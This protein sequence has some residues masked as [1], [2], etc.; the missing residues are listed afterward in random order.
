MKFKKWGGKTDEWGK[1]LSSIATER[2]YAVALLDTFYK[3]KLKPT[4]KEQFPNSVFPALELSDILSKDE[5]FD[6]SKFYYTGFSYGA[7][8]VMKL[9]DKR[10]SKKNIFKA[11]VAAEPSCN[12]VSNPYQINTATLMIKGEE[13]H[14][15]PVACRLSLIHI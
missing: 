10:V 4:D 2:G 14:Y 5:R 8:Q 13:S 6:K 3:R 1:R 11:A 12:V 15:Y 7:G 9:Q